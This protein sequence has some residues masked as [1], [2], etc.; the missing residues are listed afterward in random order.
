[1]NPLPELHVDV[2]LLTATARVPVKAHDDDACFDVH[3]DEEG[4]IMPGKRATISTGHTLHIPR[5]WRGILKERS[6]HASKRGIMLLGGVIDCGYPDDV[7][8]ILYNSGTEP[9][10]YKPGDRIAQLKYE[11]VESVWHQVTPFSPPVGARKGG[12]GS[13]GG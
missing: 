5:G 12:L 4:V 2:R 8:V 11:R 9:F 7:K 6:G 13:T 10:P 1:M 3:A